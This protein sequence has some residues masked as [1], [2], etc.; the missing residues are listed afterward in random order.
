MTRDIDFYFEELDL[1][2]TLE[3]SFNQ[4]S[5]GIGGYEYWG[6]REYQDEETYLTL[7][8]A[9]WDKEQYTDEEN[10]KIAEEI[11]KCWEKIESKALDGIE[12]YFS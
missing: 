1:D 2:V 4:E 12:D 8:E 10:A 6:S 11:N 7:G 9:T 3:C 5:S